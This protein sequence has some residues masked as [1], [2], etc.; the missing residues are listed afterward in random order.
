MNRV[1]VLVS[2][3]PGLIDIVLVI[4]VG[5]R[6]PSAVGMERW[7]VDPSFHVLDLIDMSVHL[8]AHIARLD[9]QCF[10]H[11]V[12]IDAGIF[13]GGLFAVCSRVCRFNTDYTFRIRFRE[14]GAI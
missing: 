1:P 13:V 3:D 11:F 14:T 8:T 9:V 6:G 4:E 10:K 5:Y 2:R 12:L 7:C